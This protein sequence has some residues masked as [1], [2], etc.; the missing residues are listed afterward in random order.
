LLAGSL[1]GT[2]P[3]RPV[4]ESALLPLLCAGFD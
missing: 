4:I 1:L 3:E 2:L